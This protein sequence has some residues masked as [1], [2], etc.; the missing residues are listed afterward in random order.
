VNN[1]QILNTIS[2]Y[3]EFINYS[4]LN[5]KTIVKNG[6]IVI[7]SFSAFIDKTPA[8]REKLYFIAA[9]DKEGLHCIGFSSTAEEAKELFKHFYRL[10]NVNPK[11][12]IVEYSIPNIFPLKI[13][14][15]HPL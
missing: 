11:L 6:M 1:K 14:T 9:E 3:N 10:L 7:Y 13:T 2:L 15:L 4:I 8:V 5:Q 12:P